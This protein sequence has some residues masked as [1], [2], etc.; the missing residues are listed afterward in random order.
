MDGQAD[1]IAPRPEETRT[2]IGSH[3]KESQFVFHMGSED[4]DAPAF[5]QAW[6][7][8]GPTIRRSSS[9]PWPSKTLNPT[10]E[11]ISWSRL[12]FRALPL[13]PLLSVVI[14]VLLLLLAF[15]LDAQ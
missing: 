2:G 9:F 10:P 13:S 1:G 15:Y 5:L 14:G 6:V 11:S 8:M 12:F 7:T 4:S 3:W